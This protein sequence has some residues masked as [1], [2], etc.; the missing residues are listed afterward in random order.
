MRRAA[1]LSLAFLLLLGSLSLTVNRH[2][3]M[4]ELK[5]VALFVEAEACAHAAAPVCPMHAK[6]DTDNNCCDDEHELVEADDDR[7]L[8][9]APSLP[10]TYS[11]LS[12]PGLLPCKPAVHPRSRKESSLE[13]YRPPPLVVDAPRQYQVYLI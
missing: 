10:L 11:Q 7:Q 13:N 3:C 4:G 6:T 5:S 12:L 1:P 2:F 9:D 8:I